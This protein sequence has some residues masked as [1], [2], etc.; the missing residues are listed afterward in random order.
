M[1][2]YLNQDSMLWRPQF[3]RRL[4]L[5]K[6]S[7]Y[8]KHKL[9]NPE[10][11]TE[12]HQK[13]RL[14]ADLDHHIA[15]FFKTLFTSSSF[16]A[17][18]LNERL[19]TEKGASFSLAKVLLHVDTFESYLFG[20]D[21]RLYFK[22][23]L[24]FIYLNHIVRVLYQPALII[25]K[26]FDLTPFSPLAVSRILPF[27]LGGPHGLYSIFQSLPYDRSIGLSSPF[28]QQVGGI[29]LGL[30]YSDFSLFDVDWEYEFLVAD[31]EQQVLLNSLFINNRLAFD[32][33]FDD[34]P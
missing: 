18:T 16:G 24:A 2:K 3:W 30:S 8:A 1:A 6:K 28:S 26:Y 33:G 7:E 25:A 4:R 14:V 15:F 19:T 20:T 31:C 9:S 12:F 32:Y 27:E 5:R 10:Q 11:F 13:P 34:S 22:N 21:L 17:F 23:S 29:F